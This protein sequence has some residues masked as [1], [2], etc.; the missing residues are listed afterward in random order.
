MEIAPYPS[1]LRGRR[2]EP[3]S[4]ALVKFHE[5]LAA[6][7]DSEIALAPVEQDLLDFLNGIRLSPS[8]MAQACRQNATMRAPLGLDTVGR[9]PPPIPDA[10]S[11][12]LYCNALLSICAPEADQM[13]TN[14]PVQ[15]TANFSIS[16]REQSPHPAQGLFSYKCVSIAGRQRKRSLGLLSDFVTNELPHRI[17]EIRCSEQ[18]NDAVR[19]LGRPR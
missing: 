2:L 14:P 4:Q 5:R 3:A 13:N 7:L 17:A 15:L 8:M 12:A 18:P 6:R 1:S 9:A 10:L 19:T 16:T 11:F